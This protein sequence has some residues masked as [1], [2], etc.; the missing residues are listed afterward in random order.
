[1]IVIAG[2][3]VI[4][5]DRRD[6]AVR[7]AVEMQRATEGEPGCVTYR[8]AADLVDPNTFRLFEEWESEAALARH[9]ETPHMRTFRERIP[10]LVAAPPQ[11]HRYAATSKTAM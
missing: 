5:P 7:V 3:I 6:E 11:I 10:A 4:R 9:F 2:S 8:F 1:M